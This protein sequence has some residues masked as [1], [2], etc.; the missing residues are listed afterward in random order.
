M[1]QVWHSSQAPPAPPPQWCGLH[2]GSQRS[3]SP[4]AMPLQAG[5]VKHAEEAQ[6]PGFTHHSLQCGQ[7]AHDE[8]LQRR[9]LRHTERTGPAIE[10]GIV[11][12]GGVRE[13]AAQGWTAVTRTR[14]WRCWR[15]KRSGTA[16]CLCR[17]GPAACMSPAA[18]A[19]PR[20][21]TESN[22]C[23]LYSKGRGRGGRER[24]GPRGE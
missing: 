3:G 11:H 7:K 20:R 12:V 19:S 1:P 14:S 9:Q 4:G 17:L 15:C 5:Q 8:H 13:H 23:T 24:V 18:C 22:P 6:S 21:S 2:H 10:G 16:W